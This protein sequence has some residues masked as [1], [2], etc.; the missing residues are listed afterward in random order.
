[1]NCNNMNLIQKLIHDPD[2]EAL[3]NINRWSIQKRNKEESVAEHSYWVTFYTNLL[4]EELLMNNTIPPVDGHSSEVWKSSHRRME[5]KVSLLQ[6]AINHD[7]DETFTGD[8]SS[9]V[10][11]NSYNGYQMK[12]LLKE[13]AEM[14]VKEKFSNNTKFDRMMCRSI[15]N[16]EAELYTIVKVA[17]WISILFYTNREYTMGNRDFAGYF[18]KGVEEL[19][20]AAEK[21]I[22]ALQVYENVKNCK[23][24]DYS[25]LESIMDT[26]FKLQ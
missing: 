6:M 11:H 25:I 23:L 20:Y 22:A 26:N 7:F 1:M 17:D 3:N 19:K 4:A 14:R 15:L 12:T 9:E 16:P 18:H 10:K 2:F 13:Y 24:F 8:M 21:S 5:I